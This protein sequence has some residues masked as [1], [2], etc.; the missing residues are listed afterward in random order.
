[1]K[2]AHDYL[3]AHTK[4]DHSWRNAGC[5]GGLSSLPKWLDLG[6]I[7]QINKSSLGKSIA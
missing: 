6:E 3:S 1:M 7:Q 4:K 5:V 2:R